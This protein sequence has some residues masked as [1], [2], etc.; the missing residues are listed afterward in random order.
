[1]GYI[2]I[3]SFVSGSTSFWDA[4]TSIWETNEESFGDE[5]DS[6]ILNP[7][8][9]VT[10]HRS[11][12]GVFTEVPA[13]IFVSFTWKGLNSYDWEGSVQDWEVWY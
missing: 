2:E 12:A 11:T 10:S 5:M 7:I 3:P 1:M 9:S 6:V 13:S 8:V 4:D